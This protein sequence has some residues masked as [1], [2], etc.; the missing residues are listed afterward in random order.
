MRSED[1]RKGYSKGYNTGTRNWPEHKPPFPPEPVV[2]ELM[3]ALRELRDHADSSLAQFDE[4][5]EFVRSFDVP[6][7]RADEAM[8]SVTRWLRS[9]DT[10]R[11]E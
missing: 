4:N 7:E 6:I 1:Y 8:A 10:D 3:E 5:D 9:A 2:R 11:Q